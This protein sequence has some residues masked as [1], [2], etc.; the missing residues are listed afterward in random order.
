MGF[1]DFLKSGSKKAAA[2]AT[3]ATSTATDTAAK[4]ATAA[5]TATSGAAATVAGAA[6]GGGGMVAGSAEEGAV[7]ALLG[8]GGSQLPALLDKFG[9]GGLGDAVAS[10]VSKGSNLPVSADQIKTVLESD[11]VAAVA[12]K[13]GISEDA[14]AAKIADVLPGII[15]KVTPDGVVPDPD[16]LAANLTGLIKKQF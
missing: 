1:F 10:W 13:L 8:E 15:D 11:Q 2:G 16:A 4:A 6:T 3:A 5:T 12:G 14:A 9:A 7:G